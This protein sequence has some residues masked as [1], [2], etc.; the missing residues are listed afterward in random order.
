MRHIRKGYR[1]AGG[2]VAVLN[3]TR[4]ENVTLWSPENGY[5]LGVKKLALI[6]MGISIAGLSQAESLK[7]FADRLNKQMVSAMLKKDM[8][9]VEKILKAN[10]TKDFKYT[11]DNRTMDMK[12][13][14]EQMK[15]G[16]GSMNKITRVVAKGSNFKEK[17]NSGSCKA[18]HMFE[19]TMMG[20]DKKTH[21]M[22]MSGDTVETYVKVGGKWKMKTM[23]WSNSK[24][25]MDGKP[26]DPS[27]MGGG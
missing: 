10:L 6:V 7:S 27:M 3:R 21:K 25:L 4:P 23:V 1:K 2:W 20:P 12:T 11:E 26:M 15:M 17:G 22:T 14:F 19:G 8:N 18:T 5:S 9:A 13:M 16:L 24:M